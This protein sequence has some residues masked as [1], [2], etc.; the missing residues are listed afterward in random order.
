LTDFKQRYRE[1]IDDVFKSFLGGGEMQVEFE[2]EVMERLLD[3]SPPGIDEVMALVEVMALMESGEFD[4]L[5]L[6]TAPTG[7]LLRF[8]EMPQIAT[9]WLKAAENVILKYQG[10]VRLGAVAGLVLKYSSRVDKLRRKLLNP[11]ASEILV[12]TIPEAMSVLEMNRLL[13]SLAAFQI[14]CRQIAVNMVM[15]PNDCPFC[16]RKY[17]EEQA[18]IHMIGVECDGRRFACIPR[19]SHPIHGRAEL[20]AFR[21]IVWPQGAASLEREEVE[22]GA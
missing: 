16:S 13:A 21:R 11:A 12:V 17:K 8:L 19:Y 5:V 3:L 9:D 2:Q 1:A 22:V 6:D 15:P 7:H 4:I 18:C 20:D 10:I 14:P